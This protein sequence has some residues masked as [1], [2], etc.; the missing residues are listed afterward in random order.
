MY[1]LLQKVYCPANELYSYFTTFAD[2]FE[3]NREM[4]LG[5]D[6]GRAD[7]F[8]VVPAMVNGYYLSCESQI[9]LVNFRLSVPHDTSAMKS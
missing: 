1:I 4:I 8:L 2:V 7:F 3:Q 5:D 9:T 6:K